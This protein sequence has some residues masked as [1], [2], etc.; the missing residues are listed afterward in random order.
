MFRSPREVKLCTAIVTHLAPTAS[1]T[2][3]KQDAKWSMFPNGAG[4]R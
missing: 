4:G 3:G 2:A 1:A